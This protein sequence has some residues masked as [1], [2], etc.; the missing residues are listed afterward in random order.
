MQSSISKLAEKPR[1]A[2]YLDTKA[3]ILEKLGDLSRYEIC[4]NQ[5]LLAIYRRPETTAGGIILTPKNLQEDLY[6]GKAHLVVAMGKL[7]EFPVVDVRLHDWVVARPSDGWALDVTAKPEVYDQKDFYP[8]RMVYDK[9][10]R[11]KI[12]HPAMIW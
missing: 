6:Q 11:A 10:I 8:C 7:C 12:P 4:D 2:D 5:V 9:H 1:Y 3:Q